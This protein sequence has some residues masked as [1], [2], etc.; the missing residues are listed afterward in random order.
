M[1]TEKRFAL[2]EDTKNKVLELINQKPA[3]DKYANKKPVMREYYSRMWV[4]QLDEDLQGI[5]R[6]ETN[7]GGTQEGASETITAHGVDAYVM[8]KNE[9]DEIEKREWKSE[10]VK[11]RKQVYN[12]TEETFPALDG[13]GK[14]IFY[15]AIQDMLGTIW[16]QPRA[17]EPEYF[18]INKGWDGTGTAPNTPSIF[19]KGSLHYITFDGSEWVPHS[20]NETS[21]TSRVRPVGAKLAVCQ[22][23]APTDAKDYHMPYFT[24]ESNMGVPPAFTSSFQFLS[25][26]GAKR[27]G[28]KPGEH[29]FTDKL[30]DY[31]VTFNSGVNVGSSGSQT[32][33]AVYEYNPQFTAIVIVD[34]Q[35]GGS[36]VAYAQ[37]NDET[38]IISF[39]NSSSGL[40]AACYPDIYPL[41]E[42]VVLVDCE[43]RLC[44]ALDYSTDY[45]SGTI[46]AFY[47][48]TTQ[49]GWEAYSTPAS[50]QSLGFYLFLKVKT[51]A[52][53]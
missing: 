31:S 29:A 25:G 40:S 8:E 30:Y 36:G 6:E 17:K 16:I 37:L 5:S 4:V 11:L 38:W 21:S 50:L 12:A 26:V 53:V 28:V 14:P 43:Q 18:V 41:D 7:S 22:Q 32:A 48:G 34:D 33:S 39:P 2:S 19:T 35:S 15:S 3:P 46:M 52:L 1:T 42:I 10:D 20:S 13:N 44:T 9:D 23:D 47:G 49:R 45:E 27:C 24:P 51:D